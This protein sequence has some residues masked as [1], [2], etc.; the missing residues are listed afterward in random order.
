MPRLPVLLLST[1]VSASKHKEESD[2]QPNSKPIK[3]GSSRVDLAFMR[4]TGRTLKIF[5]LCSLYPSFIER[6]PIICAHFLFVLPPA[7]YNISTRIRTTDTKKA[8][9]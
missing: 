2:S 1:D 5:Q 6:P 4:S 9:S 7:A 3:N 8:I